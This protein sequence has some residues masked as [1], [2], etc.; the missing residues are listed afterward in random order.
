MKSGAGQPAGELNAANGATRPAVPLCIDGRMVGRFGTGVSRY[1]DT[2]VGVLREAGAS[3]LL[4]E[5]DRLSTRRSRLGRLFRA[6]QPGARTADRSAGNFVVPD[7]FR[8]AHI[9]FSIH[10]RLLTVTVDGPP[11]VMH[12]TYP[13][14]VRLAGWRNIYTVHD[15]IPLTHPELTPIS[16]RRHY[17]VMNR[18][19]ASADRL[20]TVSEAARSEIVAAMGCAPSL[21]VNLSQAVELEIPPSAPLPGDLTER[22]YFLFCGSIEPR[23]NLVRLAEA[24]ARS[25]THLPLLLIGPDGWR[26]DEINVA[27]KVYPRII[28][29]DYLSRPDLLRLIALAR[30]LLFPSLAE[31]FGLP[32]AEAMAL[33]TPVMSS[34]RGAL[35]EVAA[36][37]AIGVDPFDIAAM[38]GAI[39]S[40]AAD[41]PLCA[42]LAVAGRQRA[43]AFE[44]KLYAERLLTL[45]A[46]RSNDERSF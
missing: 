19:T 3:P 38:A 27:L 25:G 7:L 1:A 8:E 10:R 15:A 9:F 42:R 13:V 22:G 12:W 16:A 17:Q 46:D 37:A 30:A 6:M 5:D 32:V 14:P 11:G 4:L 39:R 34:N 43:K 44:R 24:H 35:A 20:V 2:L 18:I 40:L 36:E 45:Y 21:V 31:G 23:K 33:G 41:D 26:A 28:R 29:M